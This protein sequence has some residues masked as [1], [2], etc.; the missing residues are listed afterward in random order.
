MWK[1]VDKEPRTARVFAAVTEDER[2]RLLAVA[3]EH[4]VE[5]AVLVRWWVDEAVTGAWVPAH[6]RK[7]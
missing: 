4:K 6:L 2:E 7:L 5:L 3:R 1:P